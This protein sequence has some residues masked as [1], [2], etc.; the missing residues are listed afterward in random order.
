M[1]RWVKTPGEVNRLLSALLVMNENC[2][3]TSYCDSDITFYLQ[4]YRDHEAADLCLRRLRSSFPDSRV[5]VRSDGDDD[6]RH[7]SFVSRYNV[8]YFPEDRVFTVE[9]GARAV[10]R[11]FELFRLEPTDFLFKL[12]PDSAV[13]RRF[14]FLPRRNSH[15]GT[16]QNSAGCTSIQGGCMGFTIDVAN[17]IFDSGLLNL[18]D[19]ATPSARRTESQY[20]EILAQRAQR[21]G[22]ASFDWS[23]GWIAT[24]LEIRLL[25]FP[26]VRSTW[27]TPV[28]NQDLRFAITHPSTT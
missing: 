5:I 9:N 27:K 28:D 23:L 26:E 20:W 3:N 18:A 7:A 17:E 8:E 19:F 2:D 24:R 14:K 12:D 6:P 15:F 10:A 1:P 13:H 11:M 22:L 4:L 25:E 16:L 21:V